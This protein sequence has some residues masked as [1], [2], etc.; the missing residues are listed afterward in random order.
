MRDHNL[1][2][3]GADEA[4]AG[5]LLGFI[6]ICATWIHIWVDVASGSRACEECGL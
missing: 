2:E 5:A 6:A 4:R 1:C 3:G